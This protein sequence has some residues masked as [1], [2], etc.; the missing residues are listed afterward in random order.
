MRSERGFGLLLLVFVLAVLGLLSLTAFA[1]AGREARGTIHLG[2]AADAFESAE[3]GLAAAADAAPGLG[4]A[5]VMVPRA[6]PGL[7]DQRS[8]ITTSLVRL[9]GSVVLLESTGERLDGAGA[10]RARCV[11][12]L[13]GVLV[14]A[15]GPSPPAFRPLRARGW[16]QLYR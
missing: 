3:Q 12:G 2:F 7:T 6:G 15:S 8:R 10:V 5:P 11:L 13:V 1:I 4:G 14:P 16:T 9:A